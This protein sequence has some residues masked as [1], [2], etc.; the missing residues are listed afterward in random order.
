VVLKNLDLLFHYST[1]A[2]ITD[3]VVEK[4]MAHGSS[5]TTAPA[6]PVASPYTPAPPPPYTPPATPPA[7]DDPPSFYERTARQPGQAPERR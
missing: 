2:D 1:E 4:L 3:E 6:E 7:S 5:A